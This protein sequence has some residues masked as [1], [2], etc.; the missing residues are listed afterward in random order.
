MLS[1]FAVSVSAAGM[2]QVLYAEIYGGAT[3]STSNARKDG[4]YNFAFTAREYSADGWSDAGDE[5]VY[6]RGRNWNGSRQATELRH[7]NYHG[8]TVE[9][10]MQ[11]LPGMG[12]SG[13]Y[14]TMAI[15]Y[16]ND[17]PYQYV[18][19]NMTWTP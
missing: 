13:D 15:E 6:F 11:Y 18:Y 1:A 19:L 9:D 10:N 5:W 16:D 2:G 7:R 3:V 12:I 14:Y 4:Y 17:N 8:Y